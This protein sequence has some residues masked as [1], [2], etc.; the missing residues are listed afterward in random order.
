MSSHRTKP[1]LEPEREIDEIA[2]PQ[3]DKAALDSA[4]LGV[5]GADVRPQRRRRRRRGAWAFLLVVVLLG[6]AGAGGWYWW[7]TREKTTHTVR[8]T[9]LV[10]RGDLPIVIRE[11]GSLDALRSEVI[12]SKVE[13]DTII[14]SLVDEGIIV[15]DEDV[16]EGKVL[17]ELDSSALREKLTQQE[18]TYSTAEAAYKQA[19]EAYDIE[20]S[21]GES[22]VKEGELNVKFSRMDLEAYVGQK[23]ADDALA[24]KVDLLKLAVQLYDGAC[25]HRRG[26]EAE[27]KASLAD[28]E[29]SLREADREAEAPSQPSKPD[30]PA[31]MPAPE[32][33]SE[34]PTPDPTSD[35]S[36]PGG[37]PFQLGGTALQRTRK[38]EADIG[39]AFEEFK[40]AADKVASYAGLKRMG[41]KSTQQLEAEQ[42]A[43]MRGQISL[44]QALT[45]REL[46]LRY[47]FP[48]SAEEL[49]S[50][51][52]EKGK[53]LERVIA[54]TRSALSQ[55]EVELK[56]AEAKYILQK[57]RLEK[58]KEQVDY[59]VIK[60]TKPGLVVYA[61]TG[62]HRYYRGSP[63]E[64]GGSVH[65]RQEIIK[66]P[67]LASIAVK[68]RVHES[69]V[70]KVKKDL[71]ARI[72]VDAFP[73][74]KLTGKVLKVAMLP[75]SQSSWLN[76]DLKEYDTDVSI[77]GD[78]TGLK[79]G[80]SAEVEIDVTTLKGVL[81]VPVQ[82]VGQQRGKTVA[83]VIR[84]DG[85]EELREVRAGQTNEKVVEILSGLAEG[86]RILL[87][88]PQ[89]VSAKDEE[90][91]EKQKKPK[92]DEI[93]GPPRPPPPSS[94]RPT[95]QGRKPGGPPS[96]EKR[97]PR[98]PS[99]G[100]A[101]QASGSKQPAT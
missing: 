59:C 96:G 75:S 86:E 26:V 21:A 29:K 56:S 5:P 50:L 68:T 51:Y 93:N 19:K 94:E 84:A 47:E 46:F 27:V 83:Y 4:L 91:E 92:D 49:L 81:Q 69:V 11:N 2:E 67:D 48:K 22:K 66:M 12:K 87:E 39:L 98:G 17:V 1:F 90:A 15:T 74:L 70:D 95:G 36:E 62:G 77:E 13:G 85:S 37:Q 99:K 40:R 7:Q 34:K 6:G 41:I 43:L 88:A 32:A 53:E 80:M 9:C 28:V 33:A 31:A 97:R 100:S 42:L 23:L 72:R 44:E 71:P 79:P 45:A 3:L 55:A 57:D 58:L 82:A 25:A 61:T 64:A 20:K 8:A 54:R 35:V 30:T 16:K 65:E 78:L 63:I 10:Q 101:P 52:R 14:I 38:L 18:L 76:P 24:S 60:A 73:N 89:I